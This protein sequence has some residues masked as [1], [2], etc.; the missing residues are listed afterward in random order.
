[1][2]DAQI[3]WHRYFLDGQVHTESIQILEDR[4]PV[5]PL[6]NSITYKPQLTA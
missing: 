2:S 6:K 4:H 5:E 1:M 3:V